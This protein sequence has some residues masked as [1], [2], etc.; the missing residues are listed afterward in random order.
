MTKKVK[1]QRPKGFFDTFERRPGQNKTNMHYCP[2]CG[3]GVMHKLIAEALA[4]FDMQKNTVFIA[5]VGCA[6]FTYYYFDCG[7]ISVP[8]GRA[9]AVA[10][11]IVRATP[12]AHVISYQ[13]DGDLAAIGLNNFIQAANRGENIAVFFVNNAIYGMTGGQMAPTTLPGQKTVTCPMGRSTVNEGYPIKVSE[14]I[15]ALDS[16]VYVERVALSTTKNIMKA[17]K[18]IRKALSNVINKKG[19]SLVEALSGCPEN[20]HLDALEMNEFIDTRMTPYFP[21]GC[22]KDIAD[23][24]DP[25]KRPV[26]IYDKE[27]VKA[28]LFPQAMDGGVDAGFENP[29]EIFKKERRIKC[30]GFGGQ[31][32]LS[33]GI[34]IASMAKLRNFNVSWLPSYGPEKRGGTANCS[35]VISRT[36][37][38]SPLINSDCNLLIAMNQP[39][40]D[41]YISE[42]KDK[43]VLLYDSSTATAP[44]DIGDKI[45]YHVEASNIAEKMGNIKCANSVM[46]G[47]LSVIM[48]DYFLEE[49]DP[50]DFDKVFEESI[51]D[52]FVHKQNII[53]LNLNA[54]HA[55]KK[56]VLEN[57]DSIENKG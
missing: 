37:V 44:K 20:L 32:I 1:L 56:A 42:L 21:L 52:C 26:G 40:I 6:V 51:I 17:R 53:K 24:R 54:F 27:K 55:G 31:G 5:P 19:F 2:G 30:A 33:L 10:T 15:A 18:A 29:S 23:N 4:D 48:H 7:G 35:V 36:D 11:G 16:P 14:M 3:H 39:S 25:I 41:K 57:L 9:P 38:G 47:A 8:H 22:F 13:G 45:V 34:M 46:L 12:N 50:Q 49:D 28:A 43:G